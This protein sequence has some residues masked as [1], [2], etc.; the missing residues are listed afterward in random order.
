MDKVH[1]PAWLAEHSE[2][3]P[4]G[5]RPQREGLG[6]MT[7]LRAAM[8]ILAMPD[9]QLLLEALDEISRP[10]TAREI[11]QALL[12]T[13]LSRGDRKRLTLALKNFPIM[14]VARP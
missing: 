11:D 2:V 13:G 3:F 7:R 8:E 12:A 1:V 9:R 5:S 14:L 10:M 6:R 4:L